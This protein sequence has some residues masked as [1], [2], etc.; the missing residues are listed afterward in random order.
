MCAASK[1]KFTKKIGGGAIREELPLYRG[2]I[3]AQ[4]GGLEKSVPWAQ[5]TPPTVAQ[6]LSMLNDLKMLL[7]KKELN[8]R[9][10]SFDRAER[11]IINAGNGGGALPPGA[12]FLMLGTKDV[13]VDI[14]IQ[15]GVA[16][17]P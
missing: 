14:E 3:Q 7:S 4:G 13:R 9:A 17:V 11:F 2:R 8:D 15:S 12:S 6:G 16:F 5:K 10:R 1:N